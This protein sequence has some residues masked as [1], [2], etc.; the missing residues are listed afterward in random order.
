MPDTVW[1]L[2]LA[3]LRED[4][5]DTSETPKWSDDVLLVYLKDAIRDY[6]TWFPRRIDR[7]VLEAE[8]SAYALPDDFVDV[9]FLECPRDT[10]LEVRNPQ[11][12]TRFPTVSSGPVLFYIDGGSL[13]LWGSPDSGDEVLLTYR[14]VHSIPDDWDDA[15]TALTVPQRDLELIR[16]YIKAKAYENMRSKQ[17]SLDRF[18][19]RAT[20]G[21][22]RQDNPLSPEVADLMATYHQKISAR[23]G[24]G[25]IKLYRSG[26]LR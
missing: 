21:S 10:Y 5:K 25:T 1:E 6:S 2:M 9:V 14:A 20:A 26:R 7:T 24:G 4:L 3:D 13:Y 19:L 18:K 17:A 23:L 15:E 11:P 8:E 22:D 12:G 16:L